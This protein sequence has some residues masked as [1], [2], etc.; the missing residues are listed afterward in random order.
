MGLKSKVCTVFDVTTAC[1]QSGID[2]ADI[3]NAI[4]RVQSMLLTGNWPSPFASTLDAI[5]KINFG[6]QPDTKVS[7]MKLNQ[8]VGGVRIVLI[9]KFVRER[10]AGIIQDS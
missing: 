5:D 4:R 8:K 9:Y 6:M 2:L 10:N 1:L 7:V 3:D